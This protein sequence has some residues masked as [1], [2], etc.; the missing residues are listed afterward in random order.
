MQIRSVYLK[1]F[2]NYKELSLKPFGGA[3]LIVGGNADG[4]TNLLEALYFCLCGYSFRTAREEEVIRTGEDRAVL[5]ALVEKVEFNKETAVEI[6]GRGKKLTVNAKEASRR[7][8][9][10]YLGTLLFRPEDLEIGVGSPGERRRFFD[11]IF[12]GILPG[13]Y[14]AYR[15]YIRTLNHRNALLRRLR[16][17][18]RVTAEVRAW[19]EAVAE[20]GSVVNI[21]RL[22][23]LS[24]LAPVVTSCYQAIADAKLSIR[25]VSSVGLAE[26]VSSLRER[27]LSKLLLI[28]RAELQCGQTLVGPHRDDFCFV[29]DGRDLRRQ[30]SRGEQRTA[31]LAAKLAEARMLEERRNDRIVYLLD[32]VFS[33]LDPRRRAALASALQGRQVFVTATEPVTELRGYSWWIKSGTV[34]NRG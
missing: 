9:P 14:S 16:G 20:T 31:V 26:S 3:N 13:Y 29:V 2:R 10:G 1:G 5:R 18:D 32:D 24:L 27:F 15:K 21:L 8:F 25:Y 34:T 17:C 30:G 6:S 22:Q 11:G 33:E 23:A 19:T 4:K 7:D 28:E 12:A